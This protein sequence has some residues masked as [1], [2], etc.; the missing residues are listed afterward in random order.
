[1]EIPAITLK[2]IKEL[3]AIKDNNKTSCPICGLDNFRDGYTRGKH[4]VETHQ[5]EARYTKPKWNNHC[6]WVSQ[7]VSL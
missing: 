7:P 1:M 5:V 3:H 4:I 6:Y 2:E